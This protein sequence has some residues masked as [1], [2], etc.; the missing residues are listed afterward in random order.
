MCLAQAAEQGFR[1]VIAATSGNYGAAIASQAAMYGLKALILQEVFDSTGRGQPEVLEKTRACEAYGAEVPQLTVGPGSST[2]SCSSWKKPAISI[3]ACTRPTPRSAWRP[4][5]TRLP[6]SAQSG[7]ADS[8]RPSSQ[9]TAVAGTSR[10]LP[11][12]F[13]A[14]GPTMPQSSE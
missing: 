3:P 1:G 2:S 4:S 14:A 7:S 10:A 8:L 12:A 9:R 11:A 6:F 5:A 13:A